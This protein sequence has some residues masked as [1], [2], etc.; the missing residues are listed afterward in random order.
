MV[1]KIIF[2]IILVLLP[3]L[4]AAAEDEKNL[5]QRA[6]AG[7][8]IKELCNRPFNPMPAYSDRSHWESL[9]Q[10]IRQQ[11][12]DQAQQALG[13]QWQSVTLTSYLDYTRSGVRQPND[14]HIGERHSKLS[15]L[16]LGELVEGKGRFLDAIANGV[17]SLCEQST[18]V[19]AA[20][21]SLQGRGTIPDINRRAIDLSSGETANA[22][23][24]TY[25]FFKDQLT[26][27]SPIITERLMAEL[28]RHILDVYI[29]RNDLW[30]MASGEGDFVNNWNPWCNFNVLTCALLV[31]QDLQRKEAIVRKSIRSVDQFINYFRSDG[32]CEEGP[33][34]WDHA[35]AKMVEYLYRLSQ[36]SGGKI[37]VFED[38]KIQNIARY[39]A[40][41]HIDSNYFVNFAD[42]GA[43]VPPIPATIFRCGKYIGD[44]SL[45][46]F[47]AYIG[48]LSGFAD[49]PLSGS[50]DIKLN[51]AEIY[52]DFVA[53]PAK[54]PF[55]K[56]VW[57]DGVEVAVGRTQAGSPQGFTFAAKGG[58]N[59][60]SHNHNDVGTFILYLDGSPM[61][62]D[63][64]VGT[65][66]AKT[67][68]ADRYKIWTMQ[69]EYH[70]LPL[71][72][73][74]PQK[75]GVDFRSR[76]VKF[77]DNGKILKF[78][79][80]LSGAYPAQAHCR[81]WLR[82]YTFD[83]AKGLTITDSYELTEARE[84]NVLNFLTCAEVTTSKAG[85][86]ELRHAGNCVLL[87]YDPT[88][89]ELT[90]SRIAVDDIRLSNIWGDHLIRITLRAKKLT[91]QGEYHIT[92]TQ[93]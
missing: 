57:M 6:T 5:L 64:G 20:H 3:L 61:V 27:M 44:S 88:V 15:Q 53:T 41:V 81:K 83:R 21:I 35:G 73:G 30:W 24:W 50:L 84:N 45:M 90:T 80:D 79:L 72:N 26:K 63:A 13:Y 9:P 65:Y 23:S 55:Y 32:G 58:F 67:F 52:H 66:T 74:C 33:A 11:A 29:Q 56:S 37:D 1:R 78:S 93:N 46:Q 18:W 31:E 17:W 10:I 7:V 8:D 75:D 70:N 59:A 77:S 51:I 42:A 47:G 14:L 2:T 87:K 71:I 19:A 43:K 38:P 25:Y 82:N 62:V 36:F 12:I 39:I 69:S 91:T 92:L 16:V 76:D 40:N 89:F 60:E 22:L 4:R 85:V 34:Y 54:A 28:N 48:S 49:K 68:S 86:I